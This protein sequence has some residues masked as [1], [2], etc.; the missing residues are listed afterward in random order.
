MSRLNLSSWKSCIALAILLAGIADMA[1]GAYA[2]TTPTPPP[3]VATVLWST[4]VLTTSGTKASAPT[5]PAIG[6][7]I[8][9][10]NGTGGVL[11]GGSGTAGPGTT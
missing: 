7:T 2:V 5:D 10:K 8:T 6:L 9:I 1:F 3:P 4:S 11:G